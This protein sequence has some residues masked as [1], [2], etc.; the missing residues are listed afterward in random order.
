MSLLGYRKQM[1]GRNRGSVALCESGARTPVSTDR[2]I[3]CACRW[4][5]E[6]ERSKGG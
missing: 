5:G 3:R 4:K 6:H 2:V 1:M